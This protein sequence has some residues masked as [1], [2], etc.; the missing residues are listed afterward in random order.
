MIIIVIFVGLFIYVKNVFLPVKAKDLIIAYS[1]QYLKRRVT[2]SEI[3]LDPLKGLYLKDYKIYDKKISDKVFFSADEISVNLILPSL[4][5]QNSLLIPTINI[6]NAYLF[7]SK[8][9]DGTW[10]FA[11]LKNDVSNSKIESQPLK[12][13]VS[14]IQIKKSKIDIK[15]ELDEAPE[16]IRDINLDLKI[17]ST[18]VLRFKGMFRSPPNV[19]IAYDGSYEV[20]AQKIS[21]RLKTKNIALAK[22]VKFLPRPISIDIGTTKVDSADIEFIYEKLSNYAQVSGGFS[23]SN[24]DI[25]FKGNDK[26]LGAA[27]LKGQE[28]ITNWDGTAF[29]M[30][31][32]FNASNVNGSFPSVDRFN[33]NEMEARLIFLSIN[34]NEWKAEGGI[35]L[36]NTAVQKGLKQ[37]TFGRI[38]SNNLV[39]KR[40]G[41]NWDLSGDYLSESA[42]F[43][44]G[45]TVYRTNNLVL[46]KLA[47]QYDQEKLLI[48]SAAVMPDLSV[49]LDN[50]FTLNA[51]TNIENAAL[52]Y[53][54]ADNS[55][56][57]KIDVIGDNVTFEKSKPGLTATGR[58]LAPSS[59]IK[60]KNGELK[61]LSKPVLNPANIV[62]NKNKIFSGEI[63]FEKFISNLQDGKINLQY[64]A[65]I[66]N[67]SGNIND[68]Y[69]FKGSPKI[70]MVLNYEINQENPFKY[71]GRI[72]T[73][74]S[75]ITGI[76]YIPV[77][78]N[79]TADLRIKNNNLSLSSVSVSALGTSLTLTGSINDFSLPKFDITAVSDKMEASTV[80]SLL[81]EELLSKVPINASGMLRLKTSIRG[82]TK[83]LKG[84]NI[85]AEAEMEGVTLTMPSFSHPIS[86]IKGIV[87][88][89]KDF[90]GWEKLNGKLLGHDFMID[91]NLNNFRRPTILSAIKTKNLD[92]RCDIKILHGALRFAMLKGQYLHSDF[93]LQGDMHF[94]SGSEPDIDLRGNIKLNLTDTKLVKDLPPK[95][96]EF[97]LLWDPAG[98]LHLK[99]LFRG[100]P[101]QWRD[102]DLS[103]QGTSSEVRLKKIPFKDVALDFMERD[104]HISQCD[105]KAAV[106]GGTVK[107][108]SAANLIDPDIF[109][110][111]T[112]QLN[113][114]DIGR[115]RDELKIENKYLNGKMSAN[116]EFH[117]PLLKPERIEGNGGLALTEGSIMRWRILDGLFKAMLIPEFHDIYFS[118]AQADFKIHE[119]KIL[120]DNFQ[121]RGNVVNLHGVGWVDFQN[122]ISFDI[123]PSFNQTTILK[124]ESFKK[125]PTALLSQVVKIRIGGTLNKPSYKA[126][127]PAIKLIT[128]TTEMI[129]D[130]IRNILKDIF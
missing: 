67:L 60:F 17:S 104:N 101:S 106:F 91:G 15:E 61:I 62:V 41:I 54:F 89:S 64:D 31:G 30:K 3:G 36:T 24:V 22:Y 120:T 20:K 129:T 8:D 14:H 115:L 40:S 39:Y 112:A 84:T 88:Y 72:Q 122:N 44:T 13:F 34:G 90:I 77:A 16:K 86:D 5:R 68:K 49:S 12:L 45:N 42:F 11:D 79:V 103:I 32:L 1:E 111:V 25:M 59:Y 97:I 102:W 100:R 87:K 28:F 125:I 38:N 80:M 83:D 94:R 6:L 35:T 27:S 82:D 121:L 46:N 95:I 18:G 119:N 126:D 117:G 26:Y 23:V 109:A 2:L 74:G 96:Q 21:A 76:P 105:I 50:I 9:I 48:S 56:E 75:E 51:S 85:T 123:I 116:V 65:T 53:T 69:T 37:F 128:G 107:I 81:P 70:E 130:G 29:K 92:S 78:N 7:I 57:G 98:I 10:N 58:L 73:T 63:N 124:S 66:N 43:K 33:A 108:S 4:F 113:V 19:F 55:L 114:L 99:G 93:N 118:D 110:N 47:L 127:S 52:R 71:E